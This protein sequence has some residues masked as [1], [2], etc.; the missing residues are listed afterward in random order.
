MHALLHQATGRLLFFK[1]GDPCGGAR[2][3]YGLHRL[4]IEAGL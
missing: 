2:R 1:A 4:K 3:N